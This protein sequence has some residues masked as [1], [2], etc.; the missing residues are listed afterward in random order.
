VLS[1]QWRPSTPLA[2]PSLS[3]PLSRTLVGFASHLLMKGSTGEYGIAYGKV[4]ALGGSYV[5]SP[6][7]EGYT[8]PTNQ[9][10]KDRGQLLM[11]GSLMLA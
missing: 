2:L 11:T 10:T 6:R 3:L 9:P 5:G 7:G 4:V 8:Q 1:I